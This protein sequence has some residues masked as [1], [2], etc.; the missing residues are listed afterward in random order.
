MG[1]VVFDGV[2]IPVL[3]SSLNS[4]PSPVA[5]DLVWGNAWHVNYSRGL[6]KS[7]GSITMPLFAS[8]LSVVKQHCIET[9]TRNTFF[10]IVQDNGGLVQEFDNCKC[11]EFSF[12]I[13]GLSGS[14]IDCTVGIVAKARDSVSASS[15]SL[16]T[17]SPIAQNTN[18]S[19]P[20]P[21]YMANVTFGG[22]TG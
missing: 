1:S 17:S 8:T 16:P 3:N 11:S 10:K 18:D 12:S 5:P 19:T 7:S 21:A 14:I 15:N 22:I 2:T 9:D 13:D 6:L 20:Y 4:Q